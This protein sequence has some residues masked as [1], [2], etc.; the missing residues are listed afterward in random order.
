[1]KAFVGVFFLGILFI[2]FADNS[3]ATGPQDV[4]NTPHNL[5]SGYIDPWTTSPGMHASQDEDEVCIF[6]HTPH[7]GSLDAP[8]WNRNPTAST[9]THYTSATL[10]PTIATDHGVRN[11]YPESMLCLSC[12]DGSVSMYDIINFS[13]RTGGQPTPPGMNPSGEM[14]MLFP[15]V[16]PVIGHGQLDT[17]TN[18]LSDDHP[19]S[20]NYTT[21]QAHASNIGTLRLRDAVDGPEAAGLVFYGAPTVYRVEC[22]TCHDPH[23]D[24]FT[25][26]A[27]QPFL[28]TSNAGSVMCLACH[29]K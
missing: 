19:I 22:P 11:I 18:D 9:F 26:S 6:C 15:G 27:Y 17:E 5:S 29:I 13:N 4:S 2:L 21:A 8:L 3:L 7:G 12:H 24:Y 28:R 23:V 14:F 10:S 20:F 25:N 1:M 16:D